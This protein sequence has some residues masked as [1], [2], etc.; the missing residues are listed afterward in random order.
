MMNIE[1]KAMSAVFLFPSSKEKIFWAA[2]AAEA[3]RAALRHHRPGPSA[4][5][6][7]EA[8]AGP[9]VQ[10]LAWRIGGC[11]HGEAAHCFGH[12]V[13][14]FSIT[15]RCDHTSLPIRHLV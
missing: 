10:A 11:M 9:S 15:I 13:Q 1:C 2:K 7:L 3:V 12:L 5:E 14:N 4:G 8:S 6:W